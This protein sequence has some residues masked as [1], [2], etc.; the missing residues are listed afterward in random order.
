MKFKSLNRNPQ[1]NQALYSIYLRLCL[2][3]RPLASFSPLYTVEKP[4]TFKSKHTLDFKAISKPMLQ[5]RFNFKVSAF[6]IMSEDYE[7]VQG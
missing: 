1:S 7:K 4:P 5:I 3:L 6:Q 2:P